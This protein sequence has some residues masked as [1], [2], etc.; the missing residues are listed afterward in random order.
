MKTTESGKYF[1]FTLTRN[2]IAVSKAEPEK[3]HLYRLYDFGE[4][5]R[6]FVLEGAL[7]QSCALTPTQFQAAFSG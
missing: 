6:L 4:R 7:D 5:P 2:E 1:P 3:Y